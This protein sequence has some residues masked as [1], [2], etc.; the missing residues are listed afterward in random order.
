MMSYN[1]IA[2]K[3]K[4]EDIEFGS[5]FFFVRILINHA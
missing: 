3:W 4:L 1:S 2:D 5:F